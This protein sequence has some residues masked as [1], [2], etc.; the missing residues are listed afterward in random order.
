MEEI[1]H[2]TLP[3]NGVNM[4]IAEKGQGQ[5]NPVIM[6]LH[7][8]PE[9]WFTWRHQILCVGSLGFH[10]VAPDLRGY[11]D[12]TRPTRARP[13]RATTSWSWLTLTPCGPEIR[14]FACLSVPF[15]PRNPKMKPV[16]GMRLVLKRTTICADFRKPSPPCLAKAN[17]FGICPKNPGP[18]PSWLK[19]D[20]FNYIV[21]K[22]NETGFTGGLNYYR[23]IDL[24]WELTEP[25]TD[26]PMMVPVK[27]EVGDDDMWYTTPRVKEYVHGGGFKKNV[28]L[29]EEIVVVEGV[30]HF[31]N[32]ERAG[33]ID[34][35]IHK[36]IRKFY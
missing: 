21:N 4:H 34:V 30:G 7:G 28:P 29:L 26:A 18:L 8:F 36:F 3:D 24:N 6:F 11:G 23:A 10:A 9:L 25:W 33:E 15:R 17:P 22:F 20:V 2:R 35:H 14:A 1:T 19:E 27:Y 16:E 32:Q 31:L 5:G 13:T 12:P